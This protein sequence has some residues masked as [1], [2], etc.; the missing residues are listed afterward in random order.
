MDAGY[1][2]ASSS[3]TVLV[4]RRP[5]VYTEM[6][7][8]G[9][10]I[11]AGSL[12]KGWDYMYAEAMAPQPDGTL[13]LNVYN[14]KTNG[15]FMF[16]SSRSSTADILGSLGGDKVDK[17]ATAKIIIPAVGYYNII[18]NPDVMTYQAVPITANSPVSAL[19]IIGEGLTGFGGYDWDLSHAIPMTLSSPGN[20]N[21]FI[22]EVTRTVAA[23]GI[24]RVLSSLSWSGQIGWITVLDVDNIMDNT[25]EISSGADKFIDISGHQGEIYTVKTDMFLNKGIAVK[26]P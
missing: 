8:Y 5:G 17:N 10:V 12:G 9:D 19:W 16:I 2:E 15:Q 6:F 13:S 14:D 24:I 1:K 21:I 18:F 26:K 4:E 22:Q 7:V 3:V 20:S 23:E 11:L 25:F